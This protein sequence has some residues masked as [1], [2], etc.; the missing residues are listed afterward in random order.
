ME[1]V[2]IS[3]R[4]VDPEENRFRFYSLSLGE[5]LWG[6]E[7]LVKRWGRIGGRKRENYYWPD[8]Y[9]DLLEEIKETAKRRERHGYQV[10]KQ[11][12]LSFN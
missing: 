12:L 2:L 8:S 6:D 1:E 4:S 7:V 11:K 3:W 5:D 10:K 9:Q